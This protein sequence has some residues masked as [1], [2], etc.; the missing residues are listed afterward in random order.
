MT[1]SA[2]D[3]SQNESMNHG[4]AGILQKLESFAAENPTT[5]DY[6]INTEY[7]AAAILSAMAASLKH[8][9]KNTASIRKRSLDAET[10]KKYERIYRSKCNQGMALH[11]F[12]TL[13]PEDELEIYGLKI[14]AH[15]LIVN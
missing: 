3:A 6:W 1:D 12:R 9:R 2:I 10:L 13:D 11:Y 15:R 7:E 4:P 14:R 8:M 5:T